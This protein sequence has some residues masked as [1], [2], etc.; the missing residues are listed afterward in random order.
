MGREHRGIAVK[1]G[2]GGNMALKKERNIE[3]VHLERCRRANAS[4]RD[5]EKRELRRKKK[6]S[7]AKK[8]RPN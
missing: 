3:D 6:S 2:S 7:T 5:S 4:E 1:K 8:K